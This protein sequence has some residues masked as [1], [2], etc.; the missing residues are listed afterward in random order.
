MGRRWLDAAGLKPDGA[1][2]AAAAGGAAA[3]D[4]A[5]AMA[6]RLEG[7][8]MAEALQLAIEY[9]PAP[10]F[11]RTPQQATHCQSAPPMRIAILVYEGMTALDAFGPYAVLSLLPAHHA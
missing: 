4:A 8:A 9:D 2:I 5:L 11:S 6:A 1:R 3:L 10:P 7:Q